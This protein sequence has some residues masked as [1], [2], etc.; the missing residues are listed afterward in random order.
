[1]TKRA[2]RYGVTLRSYTSPWGSHHPVW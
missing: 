1:V 2:Q